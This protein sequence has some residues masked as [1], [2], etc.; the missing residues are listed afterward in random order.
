MSNVVWIIVLDVKRERVNKN[1][2]RRNK[3]ALEDV[4]DVTV[5]N[6]IRNAGCIGERLE[7]MNLRQN[8]R[9][10]YWEDLDVCWEK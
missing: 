7:V 9:E 1:W 3:N 8:E 5:L 6:K 10:Y 2:S 4:C